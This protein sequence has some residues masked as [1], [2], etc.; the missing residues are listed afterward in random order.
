MDEMMILLCGIHS[1]GFAL[2]HT[3]FWRLFN[4]KEDLNKLLPANRAIMQIQNLRLI[5]IFLVM[6]AL[7]FIFPDELLNTT[8]GHFFLGAMSFFWLFRAIEQFIFLPINHKLIHLLTYL[9]ILGAII[10]AVPLIL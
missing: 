7:C 1:L 3:Q 6:A 8:I 4:W 2:F 5:Y 10:W 9:F